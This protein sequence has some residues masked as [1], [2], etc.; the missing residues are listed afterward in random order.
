MLHTGM[1]LRKHD[2]VVA[3]VD[4]AGTVVQQGSL[5]TARP[6]VAA[7]FSRALG[8]KQRAVVESTATWYWLADLLR[9][10]RV[11]LTLRHCKSNSADSLSAAAYVS[12][13]RGLSDYGC[14][15]FIRPPTGSVFRNKSTEFTIDE[16]ITAKKL[17]DSLSQCGFTAE[18]ADEGF[19][20]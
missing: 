9:A 2:L 6:A 16:V 18:N 17:I 5:P 7:Y 10:E 15:I 11:A 3:T 8:P 19:P 1:D 13:A 20:S 4:S 14:L 12:Q